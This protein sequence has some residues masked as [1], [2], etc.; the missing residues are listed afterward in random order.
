MPPPVPHRI[1]PPIRPLLDVHRP[2]IRH[3]HLHPRP[4][5]VYKSLVVR[6]QNQ[7]VEI[8]RRRPAHQ[9]RVDPQCIIFQVLQRIVQPPRAGDR[10]RPHLIQGP[11]RAAD[12]HPALHPVLAVA[13]AGGCIVSIRQPHPHRPRRAQ[14]CPQQHREAASLIILHPARL[15]PHPH[16]HPPQQRGHRPKRAIR[17]VPAARRRIR[18]RPGCIRIVDRRRRAIPIWQ[19]V[20][21]RPIPRGPEPQPERR[22]RPP[23]AALN[24]HV[25]QPR[26]QVPLH[27]PRR[28]PRIG[29]HPAQAVH[30]RHRILCRRR[31]LPPR[32]ALQLHRIL[33]DELARAH[34][35]AAQ[36]A[37]RGMPQRRHQR[38]AWIGLRIELRPQPHPVPLYVRQAILSHIARHILQRLELR[39]QRV[40][41]CPLCPHHDRLRHT[42][43]IQAAH[44][45]RE[46]VLH[47]VE[48]APRRI[49]IQVQRADIARKIISLHQFQ[50][51]CHRSP[52]IHFASPPPA[53]T[54]QP[55][56]VDPATA[57]SPCGR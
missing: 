50:L 41:G 7:T 10:H 25:G 18:V 14:S 57:S 37:F 39:R 53:A 31:R 6:D 4:I 17:P 49:R 51:K 45:R 52:L 23:R 47:H 35:A 40:L 48:P 3:L 55:P 32:G 56:A 24:C 43:I 21:N 38:L 29:I 30:V 54:D 36:R 15:I 8:Q 46:S 42:Q 33:L 34:H 28:Q 16:R 26:R 22:Q 11:A 27:R 12:H 9:L 1:A 2:R 13:R 20:R 44:A 5:A 19:K